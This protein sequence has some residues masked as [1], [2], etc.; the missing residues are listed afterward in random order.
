[1]I[2][3]SPSSA[4][5]WM[6]CAGSASLKSLVPRDDETDAAREGTTAHWVAQ[7]ILLSYQGTQILTAS[8]FVGQTHNDVEITHEMCEAVEIYV[9]DVLKIVQ[10]HGALQTLQIEQRINP[11]TKIHPENRGFFDAGFYDPGTM[12]LFVWDFKYGHGFVDV[13]ENW[14]MLNYAIGLLELIFTDN[15]KQV[16]P[17]ITIKM[18]I[19]Q[20]RCFTPA[21]IIREWSIN[22]GNELRGFANRMH[23]Q[24][25]IAMSPGAPTAT[26]THCGYCRARH[27][28]P[29]LL[30][31][32]QI[33][34]DVIGTSTPIDLPP[35]SMSVELKF[36]NRAFEIIKARKDAIEADAIAKMES[37]IDIPGFEM[38]VNYGIPYWSKP[39]D[40]ILALG[41]AFGINLI[42]EKLCSPSD[43]KK[44]G[45]DVAVVN[46]YTSKRISSKKLK[47]VNS[48][49]VNE[50][51]KP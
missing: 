23:H 11:S 18:R 24:A 40:E 5:T 26:G 3:I 50:V 16:P 38:K 49:I 15:G 20:P 44:R 9:M 48:T 34:M 46:E 51:F 27:I 43:A 10:Q 13:F 28:C 22:E 7:Q 35:Q 36:L 21:G 45:V 32:S 30:D 14:S 33:A 37:G 47:P 41:A 12:T 2:S 31:A 29:A 39:N 8:Q 25:H 17:E 4:N 6:K 19:V 1:M 42:D